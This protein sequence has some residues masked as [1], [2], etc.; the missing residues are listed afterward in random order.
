MKGLFQKI[1]GIIGILAV[2]G[3]IVMV[4]IS[5][6][7]KGFLPDI[8]SFRRAKRAVPTEQPAVVAPVFESTTDSL[9]LPTQDS[10]V[11]SITDAR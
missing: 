8:L 2:I 4:A 10:I 6:R 1:V 11:Q 5:P 9:T 3:I 7:G